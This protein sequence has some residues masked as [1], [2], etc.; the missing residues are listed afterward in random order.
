MSYPCQNSFEYPSYECYQ[1]LKE[2]FVDRELV[3]NDYII[4]FEKNHAAHIGSKLNGL[5]KVYTEFKKYLSN[6]AV[7]SSYY[8]NYDGKGTCKYISY[9]LCDK[10]SNNYLYGECNEEKFN[11]F[12][13]FLHIYNNKGSNICKDML[14]RL[15]NKEILKVKALYELYDKY[16]LLDRQHPNWDQEKYCPDM[17]YLVQIYNNFLNNNPSTTSQFNDLLNMFKVRMNAIR[18]T[19]KTRCSGK[20]FSIREPILFIPEVIKPP[21]PSER[22]SI[23][24][25]VGTSYGAGE[26]KHSELTSLETTPVRENSH[27]AKGPELSLL[28]R[29]AIFIEPIFIKPELNEPPPTG[30]RENK[31]SKGDTSDDTGRSGL[32]EVTGLPTLGVREEVKENPHSAKGPQVSDTLTSTETFFSR[33]SGEEQNPDQTLAL[34][35]EDTP[36]GTIESYVSQRSHRPGRTYASS[37]YLHTNSTLSLGEQKFESTDLKESVLRNEDVSVLGKIQ[38]TLSGIVSEVEPAPIL[39]VSGGM[40]ALFLL[41][42]YTPVGT[43]FRGGRRINNRIPRTFYGQFPGG[44][45]GYDELYEGAL[46]PDPINISYRA[47]LE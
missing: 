35:E 21:P 24:S 2:L 10:I 3:I 34:S 47:G 40:G 27:H 42:K 41:F 20:H 31:Q 13:E 9:L 7:F 32:S 1:K 23:Q 19:G 36:L 45:T 15:D 8:N 33:T 12:K 26:A 38:S 29:H 46:G 28:P 4:E 5:S 22:E 11:I 18:E 17:E 16:Y 25:Q 43:F 6:S 30:E 44:L 39:C 37:E 14:E